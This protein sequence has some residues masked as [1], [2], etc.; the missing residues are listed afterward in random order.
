MA[1][2]AMASRGKASDRADMVYSLVFNSINFSVAALQYRQAP[3][4]KPIS[5]PDI[6][7]T[8]CE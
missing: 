3:V 8:P 7:Y 2:A 4:I 1:L 6:S 5:F